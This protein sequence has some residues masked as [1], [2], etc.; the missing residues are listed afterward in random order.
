MSAPLAGVTRREIVLFVGSTL[1]LIASFGPYAKVHYT[2]VALSSWHW[3]ALPVLV[4]GYL[5]ATAVGV[6]AAV[7]RFTN[8]GSIGARVGLS[9]R[10]LA[11]VLVVVSTVTQ[12]V[13]IVAR[14][15]TNDNSRLWGF[16]LVLPALAVL[17]VGV[18]FADKIPFLDDPTSRAAP[19]SE[20]DPQAAPASASGE[21]VSYWFS[22]AAPVDTHDPGTGEVRYQLVPNTWY[23]AAADHG[24][25]LEV[26][27]EDLGDAVLHDRD[28]IQRA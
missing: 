2:D 28:V 10:E 5:A 19:V 9:A 27:D 7:D 22:V 3:F 24:T 14:A 15:H 13:T 17:I 16:Y 6:I 8:F 20:A 18:F 25:W 11:G 26:R 23:L 4:M 21:V 1:M 12:L